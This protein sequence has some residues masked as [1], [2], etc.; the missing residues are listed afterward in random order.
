MFE[1]LKQFKDLRDKAKELQ[2]ALGSE[3]INADKNG[4]K[5]TMDGNMNVSAVVL[6]KEMSKEEVEKKMPE[7]INE[8]IKKTQ[9]VMA[10]KMRAM[11]GLPGM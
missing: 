7:A 11:G 3:T 4:I 8:A 9:K 10:E 2:N 1:K 6:E 5:I